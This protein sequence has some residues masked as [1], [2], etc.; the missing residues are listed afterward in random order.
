MSQPRA[1]PLG[2]IHRA[3]RA[4]RPHCARGRRPPHCPHFSIAPASSFRP[5]LSAAALLLSR[6]AALRA[7]HPTPSLSP[8]CSPAAQQAPVALLRPPCP[9]HPTPLAFQ[10]SHPPCRPPLFRCYLQPHPPDTT[11]LLRLCGPRALS[12]PPQLPPTLL[13]DAP[14]AMCHPVA[15]RHTHSSQTPLITINRPGATAPPQ[16]RAAPRRAAPRR[17]AAPHA[18]ASLLSPPAPQGDGGP[19]R[20]ARHEAAARSINP[21]PPCGGARLITPAGRPRRARR[22]PCG[23]PW[24]P[25]NQP[26]ARPLLPGPCPPP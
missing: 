10:A 13:T 5:H 11:P 4:L 8:S 14:H 7:P 1:P 24:A 16:V 15:G 25:D 18:L 19:P 21:R 22:A 17:A 12:C 9:A 26:A 6:T 23:A 20:P 2:N 3:R